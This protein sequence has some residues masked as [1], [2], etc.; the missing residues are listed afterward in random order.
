M[1]GLEPRA[2]WW[3]WAL[4][5]GARILVISVLGFAL[6]KAF[7]FK[8][9]DA[10]VLFVLF[11]L[12]GVNVYGLLHLVIALCNSAEVANLAR[13]FFDGR[14]P[15]PQRVAAIFKGFDLDEDGKITLDEIIAGAQKLH[16]AFSRDANR[17][18][19]MDAAG[20]HVHI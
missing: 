19:T 15:T 11:L 13:R 20:E 1:A 10:G 16:R 18:A 8:R 7:I 17:G 9:A 5:L 4:M 12:Q 14:E 2:Y 3:A 6:T